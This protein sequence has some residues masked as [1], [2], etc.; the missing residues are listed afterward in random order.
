MTR[1]H[2]NLLLQLEHQMMRLRGCIDAMILIDDGTN[3][4]ETK[5]RESVTVLHSIMDE[6]LRF[7]TSTL[8]SMFSKR[9][10]K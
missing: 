3:R 8:Q 4:D 9:G 6:D 2:K 10:S 7:A 1:N 5:Y